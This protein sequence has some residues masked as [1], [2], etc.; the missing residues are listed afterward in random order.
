[1]EKRLIERDAEEKMNVDDEENYF[2]MIEF[3]EKYFNCHLRECGGSIM[4][5]ISRRRKSSGD[6][7]PKYE[8]VTFTR[9]S[10]IST[11]HVHMYDP[12]NIQ[13]ACTI[14]KVNIDYV[15]P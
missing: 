10:S 3:A 7:I 11:S 1:M 2:D 4:K 9:N 12:E 15:T 14:F 6:M 5:T 13:L 8:M